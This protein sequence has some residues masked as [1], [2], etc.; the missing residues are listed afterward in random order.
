MS[1]P[2]GSIHETNLT[3]Y[4]GADASTGSER[5]TRGERLN[6]SMH[7]KLSDVAAILSRIAHL[8]GELGNDPDGHVRRS[9]AELGVA[10]AT[11]G[12]IEPAFA[13]LQQSIDMLRHN[14]HVGSRRESE[15]RAP[16]VDQLG[17]VIAQELLPDLRR[18]GFDL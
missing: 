11:R 15:R 3:V 16:G 1:D 5:L 4:G 7:E 6:T 9:A 17:D 12:A 10:F 18:L 13:R 8:A 14:N 2:L